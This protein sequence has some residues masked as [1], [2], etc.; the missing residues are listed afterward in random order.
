MNEYTGHY[1]NLSRML[2]SWVSHPPPAP[3]EPPPWYG[4]RC[5][6]QGCGTF[7]CGQ[8]ERQ[9]ADRLAEHKRREHA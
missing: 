1:A 7:C 2:Q 4:E 3:A 9:A 6:E 8:S 5:P